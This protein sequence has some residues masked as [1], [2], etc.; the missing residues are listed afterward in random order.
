MS[1]PLPD[2]FDDFDAAEPPPSS[3][4]R[5]AWLRACFAPAEWLFATDAGEDDD[6]GWHPIEFWWPTGHGVQLVLM[7]CRSPVQ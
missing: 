2:L 7:P 6:P 4:E 5:A 1:G 3:A